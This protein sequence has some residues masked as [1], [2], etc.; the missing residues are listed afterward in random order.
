MGFFECL[1]ERVQASFVGHLGRTVGEATAEFDCLVDVFDRGDVFLDEFTD[2]V[3]HDSRQ[4]GFN[5]FTSGV[6][7]DVD[8]AVVVI[9]E[10]L[11]GLFAEFVV[12]DFPLEKRTGFV[13]VA[14]HFVHVL[15]DV[16]VH[17][18]TDLVSQFEC[19]HREVDV[20]FRRGVDFLDSREVALDEPAGLVHQRDEDTVGNESRFV[21]ANVDGRFAHRFGEVRDE[22]GRLLGGVFAVDDLDEVHLHGRVEKVHPTELLWSVR[23]FGEF[24]DGEAR[25]VGGENRAVGGSGVEFLVDILLDV[26]VLDD[27][28]D[29]HVGVVDCFFHVDDGCDT[30]DSSVTL[31]LTDDILLCE[32]VQAPLYLVVAVLDD[33]LLDVPEANVVSR[34]CS[35]FCDTVAHGAGAKHRDGFYVIEF[36][37]SCCWLRAQLLNVFFP[38]ET[39]LCPFI[40]LGKH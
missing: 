12:V 14:Q 4:S 32:F 3:G 28:L 40:S 9:V 15:G 37:D 18:V 36:H 26:H 2:F 29:D 16:E 21:L 10:S 31:L 6:H 19:S 24:R 20:V 34:E 11:V 33:V 22:V 39:T 30:L 17:V 23:D 7:R 25:G 8:A 35:N 5:V 38:T 13:G 1:D 27:C